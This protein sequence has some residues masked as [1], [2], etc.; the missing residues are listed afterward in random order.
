MS[1]GQNTHFYIEVDEPTTPDQISQAMASLGRQVRNVRAVRANHD[2]YILT[3]LLAAGIWETES[4]ADQC[5]KCP[6]GQQQHLKWS[7]LDEKQRHSFLKGLAHFLDAS[8][9]DQLLLSD[10]LGDVTEFQGIRL[11]PEHG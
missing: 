7:Q 1:H 9:T 2:G 3:E 5:E 8:R 10:I 4:G 11:K 6:P